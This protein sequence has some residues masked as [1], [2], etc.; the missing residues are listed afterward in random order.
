MVRV[1]RA[2]LIMI[3]SVIPNGFLLAV[4][5]EDERTIGKSGQMQ[6]ARIVTNPDKKAKKSNISMLYVLIINYKFNNR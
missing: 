4:V 3:P 1:N 5:T 2:K 6:G